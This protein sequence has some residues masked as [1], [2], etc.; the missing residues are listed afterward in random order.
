MTFSIT[1]MST[2]KILVTILITT[3][4]YHLIKIISIL[5]NCLIRMCITS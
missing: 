1:F 4:K 2:F 5:H 3:S